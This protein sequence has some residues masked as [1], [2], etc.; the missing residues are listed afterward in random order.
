MVTRLARWAEAVDDCYKEALLEL[1]EQQGCLGE[2]EVDLINLTHTS[3]LRR[4]TSLTVQ[5]SHH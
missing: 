4:S 2:L 1:S 5:R 3:S